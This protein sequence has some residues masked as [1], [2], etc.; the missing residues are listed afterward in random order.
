[1]SGSVPRDPSSRETAAARRRESVPARIVAHRPRP[2]R[3]LDF[4]CG[5]SRDVEYYRSLGIDAE[6]YDPYHRPLELA[7]LAG[8]FDL[9]VCT[10]V[11]STLPP[12]PRE[13]ALAQIRALLCPG[14]RLVLSVR[15]RD[16]VERE[17]R[18]DWIAEADGW[19]THRGTFQ[20]G[21][22]LAETLAL[23]AEAGFRQPLVLRAHHGI[24]V[25]ARLEG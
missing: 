5:Q 10:Y 15:D 6:G 12:A 21:F 9:V 19:R 23:L 2:R 13:A 14:G 8:A 3:L 4:G 17:R 18:E 1:V 25:E 11:L 22:D 20:R 16:E 24:T 7:P